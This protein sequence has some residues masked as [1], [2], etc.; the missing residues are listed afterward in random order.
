MCLR[1]RVT[2]GRGT[3]VAQA[4]RRDDLTAEIAVSQGTR[5]ERTVNISPVVLTRDV[6]K[7]S[8]WLNAIAPCQVKREA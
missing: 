6:S 8:G 7:L 1:G 3:A 4:V 5:G 2:G